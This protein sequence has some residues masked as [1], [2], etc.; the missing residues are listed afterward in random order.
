[1]LFSDC[2]SIST[3]AVSA[4]RAN[5][6]GNIPW[7]YLISLQQS[8]K[9]QI[10]NSSQWNTLNSRKLNQ[11]NEYSDN[12]D[13][14]SESGTNI[15][16]RLQLARRSTR[17][18]AFRTAKIRSRRC[19]DSVTLIDC[20]RSLPVIPERQL[21]VFCVF[22]RSTMNIQT[23]G[24]YPESLPSRWIR[25]AKLST[26]SIF[27]CGKCSRPIRRR[28]YLH[29][30]AFTI[31]RAKAHG[32]KYISRRKGGGSPVIVSLSHSE[33]IV[34]RCFLVKLHTCE[35]S[36][37]FG[38]SKLVIPFVKTLHSFIR[39]KRARQRLRTKS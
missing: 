10:Q 38:V 2:R 30:V 32:R 16:T 36:R 1:M 3:V 13:K 4:R 33:S 19:F 23:A 7:S 34:S 17:Y 22:S 24:G 35:M 15:S 6:I 9:R 21:G 25:M 5:G 20:A 26:A 31:A 18:R 28:L 11:R 37:S 27:C 29:L 8:R 14:L 39:I 12:D